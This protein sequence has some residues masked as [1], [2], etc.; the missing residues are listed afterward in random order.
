VRR[1]GPRYEALRVLIIH[2]ATVPPRRQGAVEP[3][4]T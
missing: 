3:E 2:E 1:G 4:F